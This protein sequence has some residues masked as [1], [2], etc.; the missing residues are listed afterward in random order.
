MSPRGRRPAGSDT[1]GEIVEAARAEFAERGY[2][3]ASLRGIARRAGVDSAL[4]HHYFA[5]KPALFTEVMTVPVDPAYLVETVIG[6]PRERVG[7][8][9]VATFLGIWDSPEGQERFAALARSVLT[10]E[11]AARML[12]E[13]LVREVFAKVAVAHNPGLDPATAELRATL[14][15]GQLLGMAMLRYL[16]RFPALRRATVPELIAEVGP[17]IQRYL[18]PDA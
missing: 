7:E 1:R 9:L 3:A 8:A 15:A 18:A 11:E 5:G 6:Q 16:L 12:R 14:A 13:F 10:H 2:D 4:V 17:V